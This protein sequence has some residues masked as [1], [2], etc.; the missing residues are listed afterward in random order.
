MDYL[1]LHLMLQ[2]QRV[3]ISR[4]PL[5]LTIIHSL[6]LIHPTFII[7]LHFINNQVSQ[8]YLINYLIKGRFTIVCFGRI[9]FNDKFEKNDH[10]N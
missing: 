2:K 3:Y 9:I 5:F 7:I 10:S 1:L 8:L 4:A 6:I